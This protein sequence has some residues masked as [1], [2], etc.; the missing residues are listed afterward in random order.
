MLCSG[1]QQKACRAL[2]RDQKDYVNVASVAE[3][4]AV[5]FVPDLDK[6]RRKTRCGCA[7]VRSLGSDVCVDGRLDVSRKLL[8]SV[9]LKFSAMFAL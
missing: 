2:Y 4:P 7:T 1:S 6:L 9:A 3:E 8:G 5:S